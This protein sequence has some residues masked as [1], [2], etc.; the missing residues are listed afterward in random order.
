MIYTLS[1]KVASSIKEP[2][3]LAGAGGVLEQPIAFGLM[4]PSNGHSINVPSQVWTVV[5]QRELSERVYNIASW[6][7]WKEKQQ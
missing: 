2:N 6:W 1:S 4:H 3:Y 7:S 5:R